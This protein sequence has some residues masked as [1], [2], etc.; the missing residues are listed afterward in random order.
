ISGIKKVDKFQSYLKLILESVSIRK[1]SKTLEL[2]VKTVLD[3]RHKITTSL[4]QING[5]KF[6]GIVECDDKLVNINEKGNKKLDRESYKR[7]SDRKTKRGVSDDKISIIVASDRKGN[8]T[9][10]VAK[11]G[12][13]D[14]KSVDKSIGD[15][16]DSQN[17]L[18]SDKH[19]SIISWAKEKEVE[20]HT[21]LS[22]NHGKN[23]MF[24]VQNVNS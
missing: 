3:W 2:N 18:C 1:A 12:R 9:M 17:I 21:F 13:I 19:P 5:T 10:K 15:L 11:R 22:K 7:P 14:T 8:P 4:E 20:H 16:M 23:K 24:H 6:V